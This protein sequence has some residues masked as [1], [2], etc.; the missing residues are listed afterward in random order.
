MQRDTNVTPVSLVLSKVDTHCE[1]SDFEAR[2]TIDD[3]L[4]R[5]NWKEIVYSTIEDWGRPSTV[6]SRCGV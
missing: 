5:E 1:G 4:V 3:V 2:A 6:G